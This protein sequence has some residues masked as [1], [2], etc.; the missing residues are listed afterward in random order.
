MSLVAGLI[1]L[2][3]VAITLVAVLGLL[4]FES[5]YAQFHAAGKA[6]PVGFLVIALGCAIEMGGA[7]ALHLAVAAA[8][9]TL[10]MPV[11]VHL[12]FRAIHRSNDAPALTH[13]D[14]AVAEADARC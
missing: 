7:A 8:G 10:T 11:S 2:V 9:L 5:P 1:V 3:G 13:D 14:L 4:R 6:S 12:L